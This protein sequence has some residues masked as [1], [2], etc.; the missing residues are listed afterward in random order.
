MTATLN[1]FL[2]WIAEA[3]S[4]DGGLRRRSLIYLH[5]IIIRSQPQKA[6]QT[7]RMDYKG[8]APKMVARINVFPGTTT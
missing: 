4:K 5:I 1:R 8:H 2:P 6:K 7:Q 3:T